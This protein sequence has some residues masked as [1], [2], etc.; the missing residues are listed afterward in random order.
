MVLLSPQKLADR[1]GIT[2]TVMVDRLRRR[3]I[4]PTRIDG[5]RRLYDEALLDKL[6][7]FF[8]RPEARGVRKIIRRTQ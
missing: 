1:L 6:Q 5:G 3:G 2:R 7:P 4:A 8:S